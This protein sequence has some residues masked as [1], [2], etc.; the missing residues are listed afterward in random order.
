MKQKC[1]KCWTEFE[2]KRKK[3]YCGAGCYKKVKHD[4]YKFKLSV[5]KSK[6][7]SLLKDSKQSNE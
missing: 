7:K 3:T 4:P 2:S 6:L 1:K 5:Q